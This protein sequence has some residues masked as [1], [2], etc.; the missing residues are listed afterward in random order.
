MGKLR[1]TILD[2][3]VQCVSKLKHAIW[4]RF[5]FDCRLE[6]RSASMLIFQMPESYNWTR[7]DADFMEDITNNQDWIAGW[8]YWDHASQKGQYQQ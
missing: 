6:E 8:H 3:T 4:Q 7:E 5:G 2:D 1:I